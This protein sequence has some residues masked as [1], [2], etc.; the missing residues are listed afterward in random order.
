MRQII[1]DQKKRNI[2]EKAFFYTVSRFFLYSGFVPKIWKK[3]PLRGEHFFVETG[4]IGYK[5]NH[6]FYAD[7]KNVTVR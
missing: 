3:A 5:K 2:F 1:L 4:H 7:F 6:E